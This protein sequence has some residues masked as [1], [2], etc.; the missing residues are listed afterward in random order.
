MKVRFPLKTKISNADNIFI[1]CMNLEKYEFP[2][3]NHNVKKHLAFK[4]KL[5]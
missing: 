5:E 3:Y 4:S 2:W 1:R